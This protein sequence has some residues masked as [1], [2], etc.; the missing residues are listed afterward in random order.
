MKELKTLLIVMV[1]AAFGAVSV[2]AFTSPEDSTV[3][4]TAKKRCR[5]CDGTG[6][7]TV[8]E[9]HYPCNG[10]GCE[11]CDWRGTVPMQVSCSACDGTGWI[12][13]VS[14]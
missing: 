5:T 4:F 12:T 1:M 3:E 11:A 7:V 9:T 14:R 6:K 8:Q 13:T 2:M 10:A